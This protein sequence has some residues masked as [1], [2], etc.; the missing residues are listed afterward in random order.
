MACRGEREYR[1]S[2]IVCVFTPH[3]RTLAYELGEAPAHRAARTDV[4]QTKLFQRQRLF[5]L[6]GIADLDNDIEID[7]RFKEWKMKSF[8]FPKFFQCRE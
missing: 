1:R 4:E 8:E 5:H 6:F 3:Y 7:H 2:L